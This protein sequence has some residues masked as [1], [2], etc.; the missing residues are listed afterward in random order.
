M[1]RAYRRS[2]TKEEELEL[3]RAAMG[4]ALEDIDIMLFPPEFRPTTSPVDHAA[5]RASMPVL[6]PPLSQTIIDER[7]DRT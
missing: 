6:S 2:L 3:I 1:S 4:D 5:L 7:G